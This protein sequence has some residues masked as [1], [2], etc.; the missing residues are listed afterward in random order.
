MPVG[1]DFVR[2]EARL[3]RDSR[4]IAAVGAIVEHAGCHAGMGDV[5]CAT[6]ARAAELMCRDIWPVARD[7]ER[8]IEVTCDQYGDRVEVAIQ[9]R[10]VADANVEAALEKLRKQLDRA[11]AEN[12]DGNFR[13][14][15]VEYLSPRQ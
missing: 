5:R 12:R 15:L 1:S 3:E 9:G 4:L 6:L 14:T 11:S 13:I 2:T 10:G 7:S 8:E